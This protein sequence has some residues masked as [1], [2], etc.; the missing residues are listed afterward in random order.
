MRAPGLAADADD[1]VAGLVGGRGPVDLR[2]AGRP[3]CARTPRD[4]G[5]GCATTWSLMAGRASRAASNSGKRRR[6][7][8]RLR[9][10]RHR[11]AVDRGLE[12]AVG[13]ARPVD[14]L[15]ARGRPSRSVAP[16]RWPG[17]RP[18]PAS[19]SAAWKARTPAAAAVQAGRPCSSGSR[20]RRASS[21]S[22]PVGLDVG[23][24]LADDGV[25]DVG[26]LHAEGAAEAAADV[27]ARA[28]ASARAPRPRRAARGAGACTPSSRRPEQLSW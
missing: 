3:R 8:A 21:S 22:A 18:C 26:V 10:G 12:P 25:G 17:R 4:N 9:L 5:R 1:D 20:G 13:E 2:A 19:T 16:R 24:L 7:G 15:E 11:R 14:A 6:A 27:A 28:A 23:G